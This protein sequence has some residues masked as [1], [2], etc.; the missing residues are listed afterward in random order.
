MADFERV[1]E[2]G[3]VII[4]KALAG[5]GG[6]DIVSSAEVIDCLL[7]LRFLLASALTDTQTD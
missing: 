7:D 3:V 4:D 6:R 1:G 2:H 5:I